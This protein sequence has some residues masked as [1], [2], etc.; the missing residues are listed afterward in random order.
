VRKR[1]ALLGCEAGADDWLA[2]LA[3]EW[4]AK[5]DCAPARRIGFM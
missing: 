2:E 5:P 3:S 4:R 1:F